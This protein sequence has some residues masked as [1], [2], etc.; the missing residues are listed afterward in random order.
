MTT[1]FFIE[2]LAGRLVWIQKANVSL[3]EFVFYTQILPARLSPAHCHANCEERGHIRSCE[4]RARQHR[5]NPMSKGIPKGWRGLSPFAICEF[6]SLP[7]R[8]LKPGGQLSSGLPGAEQIAQ[9]FVFTRL[10]V[11]SHKKN[12]GGVERRQV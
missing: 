2:L 4:R 6:D 7:N 3:A 10:F 5:A 9:G 8:F 11:V 1:P 12:S